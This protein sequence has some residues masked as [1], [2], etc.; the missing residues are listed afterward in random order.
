G[1]GQAGVLLRQ[2]RAD[3]PVQDD[4]ARGRQQ[5]GD[6]GGAAV[7]FVHGVEYDRKTAA[8][9]AREAC[10]RFLDA[11][12]LSRPVYEF[13]DGRRCNDYGVYYPAKHLVRVFVNRCRLPSTTNYSWSW[14][15]YT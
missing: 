4:P 3:D 15:G 9:E 8:V 11:N 14:P 1:L 10:D 13:A 12:Q 7:I 5:P 2:F 6:Q